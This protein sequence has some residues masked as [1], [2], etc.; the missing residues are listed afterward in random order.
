[1]CLVY[2]FIV[3]H[4]FYILIRIC[5][6]KVNI[7]KKTAFK[8]FWAWECIILNY[9]DSLRV[10]CWILFYEYIIHNSL[11]RNIKPNFVHPYLFWHCQMTYI[12]IFHFKIVLI[13][14]ILIS[15]LTWD[16]RAGLKRYN[17]VIVWIGTRKICV[18]T[19]FIN[20]T[21]VW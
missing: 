20:S 8:W 4:N 7:L 15:K 18:L 1:M 2:I 9:G 14:Y 16:M 6:Q 21:K 17:I 19:N 12:Q 5:I 11:F 10:H 13:M 3:L